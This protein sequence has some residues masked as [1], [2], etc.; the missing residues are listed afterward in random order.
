MRPTSRL[1]QLK[2]QLRARSAGEIKR[3]R[4]DDD[5]ERVVGVP[6]Q[7][8]RQ[9]NDVWKQMVGLLD[10]VCCRDKCQ[11]GVDPVVWWKVDVS[12]GRNG[13]KE[14]KVGEKKVLGE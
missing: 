4:N 11:E 5:V 6:E 3:R 7:D 2:L 9:L 8:S 1:N 13:G 12:D 10:V 14:V